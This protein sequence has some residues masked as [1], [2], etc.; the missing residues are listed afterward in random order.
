[1]K[2]SRYNY[3]EWF[4]LYLDDE[5]SSEDRREVEQFVLENPDLQSELN[6]LRQSKLTPDL[7][8]IFPD[9]MQLLKPLTA[10]ITTDNCE[11]YLLSYID[12]ELNDGEKEALENFLAKHP[13]SKTD[14]ELLQKTKLQPEPIVF[15]DKSS[16]Y[17]R[18]EKVKV[19]VINWR[20]IAIAASVI[21]AVGTTAI[22]LF[23]KDNETQA[24]VDN[25]ARP[26]EKMTNTQS[27]LPEE[28]Q[29]AL[30]NDD[31]GEVNE[32]VSNDKQNAVQTTGVGESAKQLNAGETKQ[33]RVL[34]EETQVAVNH[35][36]QPNANELPEPVYNPNVNKTTQQDNPIAMT[37]L[38][39]VNPL[40]ISKQNSPAST[41]TPGTN[42]ALYTSNT[43]T[44]NYEPVDAG[45]TGK[46]NKLRGFFRKITRTFEK[47]TNIKATDDE[48]RLLIGGLAIQ[49]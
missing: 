39:E 42:E 19:A 31:N 23:N 44:E 34:M 29:V 3:E 30:R 24:I 35:V 43:S 18:E 33:S 11:G 6:S 17:R 10:S 38:P 7:S 40:T 28:N 25:P 37:E 32:H 15:P 45:Q 1:M 9:R 21:L 20:R 46:K 27:R 13:E 8:E 49:L 12:G 5:L 36:Q 2:I 14:L 48:D 22:L 26:V 4:I 47:N 16:L 41:V